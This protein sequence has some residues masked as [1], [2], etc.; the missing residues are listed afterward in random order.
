[1]P[2]YVMNYTCE[3]V[4]RRSNQTDDLIFKAGLLLSINQGLGESAEE[5]E[6]IH[7]HLSRLHAWQQV[8]SH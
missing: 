8:G 1:M 2:R 6:E 3:T 4:V 5:R 7:T